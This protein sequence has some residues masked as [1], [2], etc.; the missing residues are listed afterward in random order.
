MA[1]IG[2][3]LARAHDPARATDEPE[4]GERV[5]APVLPGAALKALEQQLGQPFPALLAQLYT[6]VGNGGFEPGYG[7]V[8]AQQ[9][10]ERALAWTAGAGPQTL[11]FAYWGCTVCSVID[12]SAGRV[13]LLDL[14]ALDGETRPAEVT[15]WQTDD[16]ESYWQAWL[17][18]VNLFF[19]LE[20]DE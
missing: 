6:E 4:M 12:L 14:D 1:L 8:S 15:W 3:T 18:G 11:P 19:P 10:V 13:G 5:A 9:A 16:L 20:D 2:A 7:L 17:D